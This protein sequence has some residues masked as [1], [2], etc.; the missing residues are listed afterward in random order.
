MATICG[1]LGVSTPNQALPDLLPGALM[2]PWPLKAASE[3]CGYFATQVLAAAVAVFVVTMVVGA[4]PG[5]AM[6]APF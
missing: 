2:S 6:P 4:V 3:E 1:K 5:A